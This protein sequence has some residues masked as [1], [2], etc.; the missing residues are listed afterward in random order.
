[1]RAEQGRIARAEAAT[2]IADG[3]GSP[4]TI[5]SLVPASRSERIIAEQAI[6]AA[7]GDITDEAAINAAI[8]AQR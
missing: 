4:D 8:V 5:V 3:D 7:G 1:M 2:A 6:I